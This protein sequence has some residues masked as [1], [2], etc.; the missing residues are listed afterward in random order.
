MDPDPGG[1]KSCGS[2][3]SGFGS[4]TGTLLWTI[5]DLSRDGNFLHDC[6]DTVENLQEGCSGP[7][8]HPATQG[9]DPLAS[10]QVNT[11]KG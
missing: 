11:L 8:R 6:L 3:G 1:P 7:D 10:V 4:G 2:G 9:G 5:C